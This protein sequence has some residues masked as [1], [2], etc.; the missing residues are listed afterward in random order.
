MLQTIEHSQFQSDGI[1]K[2]LTGKARELAQFLK[3]NQ[4]NEENSLDAPPN[5]PLKRKRGRPKK[6]QSINRGESAPVPPGFEGLNRNRP[7]QV[8]PIDD[9]NNGMVGQVV[10]GVVEAA[11]DAGYLLNV[12][13]GNSNIY[14]RGVVFKPGHHVPISAGNDVAP[15]VQM[16][17]RND[18]HLPTENQTRVRGHKARSRER[19]E[20]HVNLG[21]NEATLLLNGS[22]LT[23]QMH[24]HAP[25]TESPKSSKRKRVTSVAAPDVPLVGSRGTVVPVILQPVNLSNALTNAQQIPPVASLAAQVV[26]SKGKQI[27]TGASQELHTQSQTY[28]HITPRS[29]QI[30]IGPSRQGTSEVLHGE[31]AQAM[32]LTSVSM[33]GEINEMVQVSSHFSEMQSE[34]S[35]VTGISSME[36][37]RLTSNEPLFIQ[38]LQTIHSDVH[39]QS[40]PVSKP[41]EYSRTGRMTQLLQEKMTA[42]QVSPIERVDINSRLESDESRS[43]ETDPGNEETVQ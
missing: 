7:Q 28:Y 41:L 8:D 15:H 31:E 36:D 24:R 35:K 4:A 29:V 37:S 39:N 14:L 25:R 33:P 26:P 21:G 12:R 38:P 6:D 2:D 32:K 16:I 20:Q 23:S 34:K 13:I 22:Q 19:N 40:A 27:E 30:D 42:N 18:I 10:T 11:F 9:G 5:I 1:I 43:P 3:M 17:R